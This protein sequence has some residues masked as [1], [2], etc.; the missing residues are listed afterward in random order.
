MLVAGLLPPQTSSIAAATGGESSSRLAS[1]EAKREGGQDDAGGSRGSVTSPNVS[2]AIPK[3]AAPRTASQ[4]F[5]QLTKDLCDIFTSRGRNTAWDPA[6]GQSATFHT[7]LVDHVSDAVES[8]CKSAHDVPLQERPAATKEDPAYLPVLGCTGPSK[9][10]DGTPA[11]L[12]ALA[13][14]PLFAT[15]PRWLDCPYL[16]TQ[17]SRSR[18]RHLCGLLLSRR[19]QCG[20]HDQ[21]GEQARQ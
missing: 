4:L 15:L 19:D 8:H 7:V 12:T 2:K 11:P 16:D 10:L 9:L 18:S 1:S 17:A 5:P 14:S 6:R 3:R 21:A 20:T 13:P